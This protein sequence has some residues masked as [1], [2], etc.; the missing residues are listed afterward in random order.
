MAV[1]LRSAFPNGVSPPFAVLL[2]QKESRTGKI[3]TGATFHGRIASVTGARYDRRISRGRSYI[4]R[5]YAERKFPRTTRAA[6]LSR[7]RFARRR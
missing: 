3:L 4:R 7:P 6:I 5:T 2:P 1:R